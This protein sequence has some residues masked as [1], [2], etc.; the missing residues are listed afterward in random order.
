MAFSGQ[1]AIVSGGAQGLG[2]AIADML[3][4][5]GATVAVFDMDATKGYS[6]TVELQNKGDAKFFQV[7]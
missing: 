4:A 3:L 7:Q 5:N 1:V 6:T 2:E